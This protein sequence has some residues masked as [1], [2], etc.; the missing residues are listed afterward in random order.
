MKVKNTLERYGAVTMIFHWMMA[1]LIIGLIG[2]GLYMVELPINLKKLKLY[3]WHKEYGILV[4]MLAIMRI[5]WRFGNPTPLLPNHMKSWEKL[6]A[7]GAHYAF[8]GFMF[9]LP[10][11]GW[12]MSSATG[13]P[14]SFFGL[15]VL[16][17]L[18]AANEQWQQLLIEIHKWLGY[19]LIATIV[20]HMGA[21]LQHHY[22]YKDDILRRML[23]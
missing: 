16:P 21:A 12:M 6:A 14:V 3:G 9:A 7:H 20:G 18:V 11:T 8:Y 13:L 23:P 19:G 1:I 17:D 10:L 22:Y 15:F 2:L 5:I 4:F